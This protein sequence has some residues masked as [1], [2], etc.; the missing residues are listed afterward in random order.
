MSI[1]QKRNI[2]K[3]ESLALDLQLFDVDM[4][5][6]AMVNYSTWTKQLSQLCL[7]HFEIFYYLDLA[8]AVKPWELSSF[9]HFTFKHFPKE[10][11]GHKDITLD[12]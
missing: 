12:E 9:Q 11:Y 4:A 5:H 10:Y 1:P 3:R 8:D 6:S 7:Q 2:Q